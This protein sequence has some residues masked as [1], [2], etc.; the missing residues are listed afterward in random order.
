[1]SDNRMPRG[2]QPGF[3]T[4]HEALTDPGYGTN[5][6]LFFDDDVYLPPCALTSTTIVLLRDP[7]PRRTPSSI[8]SSWRETDT[9]FFRA[10]CHKY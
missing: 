5:A 8:F 1:M 10:V 4:L 6:S 7:K 9:C 2:Q 3:R